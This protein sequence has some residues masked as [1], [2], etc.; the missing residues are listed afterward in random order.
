MSDTPELLPCPHCGSHAELYLVEDDEPDLWAAACIGCIASMKEV[1]RSALISSWNT[2][3]PTSTAA[4]LEAE[5]RGREQER[6]RCAKLANDRSEEV[7]SGE[8]EAALLNLATAIRS[9]R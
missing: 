2:R 5:N 4:L 6:E 3:V 1:G 8:V 9:A 7:E